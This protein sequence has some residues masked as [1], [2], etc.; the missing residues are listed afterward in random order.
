MARSLDRG[1]ATL[2]QP[3]PSTDRPLVQPSVGSAEAVELAEGA[4]SALSVGHKSWLVRF[5]EAVS[6]L[7]LFLMLF[8]VCLEIVLRNFF[9]TS[10]LWSEE[11]SRYLMI[12]SVYFGA[13]AAISNGLHLRV[14][15]V[16]DHVGPRVRRVL[17]LVA[18]LWVLGFSLAITVAGYLMVRDTFQINMMSADSN[19]AIP[20]GYI[21]L[22]IPLT[23]GLSVLHA[24][25]SLA[26]IVRGGSAPQATGGGH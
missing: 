9:N 17:D 11:V 8:Q 6:A 1:N 22:V 3:L 15:M 21:Q 7:G 4:A 18:Q 19:L 23:F 25:G 5:E 10:F 24:L 14:D 16:I 12:W 26:H 20:L 13:S 2:T